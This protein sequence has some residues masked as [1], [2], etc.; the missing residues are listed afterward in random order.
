M[1]GKQLQQFT[2][3]RTELR[4]SLPK[5]AGLSVPDVEILPSND[6]SLQHIE[7]ILRG[8]ELSVCIIHARGGIGDVL[9]T[10]PTIRAIKKRYKCK[11]TYVTDFGYLNGVLLDTLQYNPDIE[12]IVDIGT[13]PYENFDLVIDLTMCCFPFEKPKYPPI[14]RIDLFARHA[15]LPELDNTSLFYKVTDK[16]KEWA[17][18]WLQKRGSR[19]GQKLLV[20]QLFA[21]NPRRSPNLNMIKRAIG[22]MTKVQ[23]NLRAILLTHTTDFEKTP[24]NLHN[25]FLAENFNV[26]DIAALVDKADIVLA[27]DSGVLHIAGAL[28]KPLIGL[29]GPTDPRARI[30][31]YPNSLAICPGLDLACWPCWYDTQ[32]ACGM[33]CWNQVSEDT[34]AQTVLAVLNQTV[35]IQSEREKLLRRSNYSFSSNLL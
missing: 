11:I 13:Q 19:L 34:I 6:F 5:E 21:S 22:I 29:F 17:S 2:R 8:E 31:H 24:L 15:G 16:E 7:K 10:T 9:M 12:T 35:N 18:V 23:P 26:R 33:A 28:N 32:G 1:H 25:C 3:R 30:N 4:R 14:N 20:V 27:P